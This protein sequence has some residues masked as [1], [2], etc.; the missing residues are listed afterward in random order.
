MSDLAAL[1]LGRAALPV[2]AGA[3]VAEQLEAGRLAAEA[4]LGKY[5]TTPQFSIEK[6]DALLRKIEAW[7]ERND[8]ALAIVLSDPSQKDLP[9][10]IR[11]AFDNVTAQNFLLATFTRAAWGL[12]PWQSGRVALEAAKGQRFNLRWARED[13]SER[14]IV[15]GSIVRMDEDGYL[16]QLFQPPPAPGATAGTSA[17]GVAPLVVWALVV[18]AVAIAALFLLYL[19]SGK[20][21]YENNRLMRELCEQAQKDGDTATVESCIEATKDLQQDGVLP[22]ATIGKGLVTIGLVVGLVWVGAKVLPGLLRESRGR[23]EGRVR[24]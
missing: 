1:A 17:F 15:F 9:E 11:L 12:G 3:T 20:R 4:A 23:R 18:A 14:L 10:Q 7:E 5:V 16:A 2:F 22:T 8:R 21:L 6:A 19:Y 24:A 13:A